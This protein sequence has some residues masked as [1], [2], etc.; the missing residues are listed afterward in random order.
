MLKKKARSKDLDAEGSTT[1]SDL[2][3]QRRRSSSRVKSG[4]A[5]GKSQR[6]LARVMLLVAVGLVGV[7]GGVVL[8]SRSTSTTPVYVTTRAIPAGARIVA[9]DIGVAN[10][11]TPGVPGALS[12]GQILTAHATVGLLPGEVLT[13]GLV[14]AGHLGVSQ[15]VIGLDL[16]PGHLPS[17]GVNVGGR[18]EV[19]FTGQQPLSTGPKGS[20]ANPGM[21]L[22]AGTVT[23]IIPGTSGSGTLVDL[24]V[25]KD[26][27]PTLTTAG[28]NSDISL[29]RV[30]G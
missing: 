30:S 14:S 20:V 6:R 24:L 22:G 9:A 1:Q 13:S 16:S 18:V 26:L 10:I 7:T 15:A 27:A 23:S 21:V 12:L 29:A 5:P 2:P 19:V 25:S 3:P 28:A 11:S 17:A 4:V 8:L